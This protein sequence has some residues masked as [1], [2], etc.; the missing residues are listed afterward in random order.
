MIK[1]LTSATLAASIAIGTIRAADQESDPMQKGGLEPLE[2]VKVAGQTDE[3]ERSSGKLAAERAMSND[4]KEFGQHM[5]KDHTQTTQEL[6]QAAKQG[7]VNPPAD[8][9]TLAPD[10]KKALQM[11][12]DCDKE[13]FD[14]MYLSFQAKAHDEALGLMKGYGANGTNEALAKA[15]NQT[16]PKIQQHLDRIHEIQRGLK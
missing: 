8:P 15:A 1:L 10:Q 3:F 2:F 6:M 12:Q 14:G 16:A 7:G 13:K 11:L 5:V 4:V 9:P